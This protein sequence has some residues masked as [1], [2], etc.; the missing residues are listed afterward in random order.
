MSQQNYEEVAFEEEP[1]AEAHVCD[2]SSI[3]FLEGDVKDSMI[4]SYCS[5]LFNFH[6][7]ENGSSL[8][9]LS[10]HQEIR[11]LP[12]KCWALADEFIK[13]RVTKIEQIH[14]WQVTV[15]E[16]QSSRAALERKLIVSLMGLQVLL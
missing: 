16:G 14:L 11:N 15:Q 1:V 6:L 3:E 5:L 10:N 13:A 12:L 8:Y 7:T 4:I 9:L 2:R